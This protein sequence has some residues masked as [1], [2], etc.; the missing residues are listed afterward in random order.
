MKPF[1]F[2]RLFLSV[3]AGALLYFVTLHSWWIWLVGAI[4][5]R[6]IYHFTESFILKKQRNTWFE[7][8]AYEFKQQFGPYGIRLINKAESD[9][10]L[11]KSLCDVFI[12]DLT[13]LQNTVNEL[14]MMEALF[15]SG[16][17][18][19]GDA[20]QLHDLKLKYAKYRLQNKK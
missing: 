3:G 10:S 17:R 19:D 15:N 7:R 1:R 16:L 2:Y 9:P 6:I 11:K 13:T 18:P 4:V 14:E 5:F 12:P 8:H 20:Y